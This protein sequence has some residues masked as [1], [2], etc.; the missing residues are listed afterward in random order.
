[1]GSTQAAAGMLRPFSE[2][3]EGGVLLDLTVR[4]LGVFDNFVA[5]LT[6]ETGI[7]LNYHRTGTLETAC[8][9]E[10]LACLRSA[11]ST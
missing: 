11:Q 9:A 4:S 8:S 2:S 3:H 5:R 10:S 1:M 7:A 6:S